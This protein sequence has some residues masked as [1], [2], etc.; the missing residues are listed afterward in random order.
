MVLE[1]ETSR[2]RIDSTTRAFWYLDLL[3]VGIR[4]LVID[5]CIVRSEW[6]NQQMSKFH[7][8]ESRTLNTNSNRQ[9]ALT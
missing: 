1:Q 9:L 7:I 5:S 3:V 6:Q 8:R 2:S 4:Y